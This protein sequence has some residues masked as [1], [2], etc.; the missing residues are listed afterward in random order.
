M[1]DFTTLA[2]I[3]ISGAVT[4]MKILIFNLRQNNSL[5]TNINMFQVIKHQIFFFLF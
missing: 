2:P 3:E 5:L 1:L 4:S